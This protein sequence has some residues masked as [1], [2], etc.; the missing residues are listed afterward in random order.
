[1]LGEIKCVWVIES[2]MVKYVSVS[3]VLWASRKNLGAL[4]KVQNVLQLN[5]AKDEG[6]ELVNCFH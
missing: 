1:M 5:T 4:S 3:N 6:G 2:F